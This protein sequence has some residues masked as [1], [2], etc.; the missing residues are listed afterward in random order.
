MIRVAAQYASMEKV[1][2]ARRPYLSATNPKTKVPMNKPKKVEATNSAGPE[3]MPI[4]TLVRSP[5]FTIPGM[6]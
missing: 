3:N 5:A 1:K 4:D 2:I 6:T